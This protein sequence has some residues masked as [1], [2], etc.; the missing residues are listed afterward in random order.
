MLI[1]HLIFGN[2]IPV[3]SDI[4]A[5]RGVTKK[6]SYHYA[7]Q[8]GL[9][10]R[11]RPRNDYRLDAQSVEFACYCVESFDVALQSRARMTTSGFEFLIAWRAN[12]FERLQSS[13]AGSSVLSTRGAQPELANLQDLPGGGQILRQTVI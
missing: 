11:R 1:E 13:R 4:G 7:W 8:R 2:D 3:D 10:M 12:E 6:L 5:P 9:P